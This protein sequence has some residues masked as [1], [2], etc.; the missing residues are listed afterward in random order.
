MAG[1]SRGAPFEEGFHSNVLGLS[2]TRC[3]Y[4]LGTAEHRSWVSGWT[5]AELQF[6]DEEFAEEFEATGPKVAA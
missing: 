3:P 2:R 1:L 6:A 4:A 5:Q